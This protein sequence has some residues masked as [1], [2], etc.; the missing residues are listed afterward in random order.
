MNWAITFITISYISTYNL[1]CTLPNWPRNSQGWLALHCDL[2]SL[3]RR[4]GEYL[5][6]IGLEFLKEV[7]KTA[8]WRLVEIHRI[9][10]LFPWSGSRFPLADFE[11]L[12]NSDLCFFRGAF[13]P[14]VG[15]MLPLVQFIRLLHLHTSTTLRFIHFVFAIQSTVKVWVSSTIVFLGARPSTDSNCGWDEW[16][17]LTCFSLKFKEICPS[18]GSISLAH[19][20]ES[21]M[22]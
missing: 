20:T 14:D 7:G 22:P 5:G 18:W 9:E 17:F 3:G 6:G 15:E 11:G 10:I 4:H 16:H 19:S 1:N 2:D 12:S 21:A 13:G 8:E